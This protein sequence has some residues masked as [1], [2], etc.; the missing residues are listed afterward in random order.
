[1]NYEDILESVQSQ[2]GVT[3]SSYHIAA[4]QYALTFSIRELENMKSGSKTN[5]GRLQNRINELAHEV[6]TVYVS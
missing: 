4:E 5:D 2:T 6:N 1:M 3:E